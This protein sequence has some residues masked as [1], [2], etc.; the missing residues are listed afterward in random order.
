[1]DPRLIV[2]AALKGLASVIVAEGVAPLAVQYLAAA[3]ALRAWIGPP[4]RL[5]DESAVAQALP[6]AGA[7][8]GTDAFVAVGR[9]ARAPARTDPQ[10]DCQRGSVRCAA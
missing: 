5:A 2:A 3:S 10:R 6:I 1:M 7:A 8:L 4:R 9:G